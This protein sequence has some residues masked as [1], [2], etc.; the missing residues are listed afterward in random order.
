M[1]TVQCQVGSSQAQSQ[2]LETATCK[3]KLGREMQAEAQKQVT[4]LN[5]WTSGKA[6]TGRS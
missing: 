4:E 6:C 2:G 3:R 1:K 5:S